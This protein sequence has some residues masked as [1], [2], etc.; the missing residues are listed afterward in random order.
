M[1]RPV[2][3]SARVPVFRFPAG[4]GGRRRPAGDEKSNLSY[5]A[6]DSKQVLIRDSPDSDATDRGAN[7]R[8]AGKALGPGR[9]DALGRRDG[10]NLVLKRQPR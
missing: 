4:E 7:E 10:S 5:L 9:R 6:K 3:S 8:G 1:F 2:G